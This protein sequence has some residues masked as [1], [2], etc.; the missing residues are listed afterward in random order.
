VDANQRELFKFAIYAW[1]AYSGSRRSEYA[2]TV[3]WP[4]NK[5]ESLY[6]DYFG[7]PLQLSDGG[8]VGLAMVAVHSAD[9]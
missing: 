7:V 3:D 4:V 9:F 2:S 6:A 1:E 8:T 5:L